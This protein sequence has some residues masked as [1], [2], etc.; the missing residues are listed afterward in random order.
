MKNVSQY[1]STS[2][3]P[4]IQLIITYSETT[5]ILWCSQHGFGVVPELSV[6]EKAVCEIMY[7]GV[8]HGFVLAPF[9]SYFTLMTYPNLCLIVNIYYPTTRPYI[10]MGII[11]KYCEQVHSDLKSFTD[12][13]RANQLCKSN[14]TKYILF[15][16]SVTPMTDGLFL[17]INSWSR[18]IP[19]N[20]LGC[21]L[22]HIWLGN[23]ILN[24]VSLA[25]LEEYMH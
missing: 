12:W 8:P 19:L 2:P 6:P 25:Y 18:S 1:T 22:I 23:I 17:Q 4:L 9:C 14:K 3:K 24:I 15:S 13:F 10:S 5:W 21:S 7:F 16:K 11:W 20:F